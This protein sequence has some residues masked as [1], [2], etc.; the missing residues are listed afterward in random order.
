MRGTITSIELTSTE[1][2][3]MQMIILQNLIEF[4]RICRKHGIPYS[5][6][7]GTMLGAVRHKGFIPWDPDA[8]IVIMQ[9]DYDRFKQVCQTDLDTE[10]FFL[11]DY[12]TDSAYRW[13]YARMLRKGT[14]YI[15]AGHEHI[16]SQ[17]GVFLDIFTMNS[18]PDNKA[19]R[20]LHRVA[21][22]LIRKALWAE[23]GKVTHP[24]ALIRTWLGLLAAL[25]RKTV[26]RLRDGLAS[27]C[28]RNEHTELVRHMCS[29]HPRRLPYG[30][31]RKLFDNL[32]EYE[33]EGHKLLGFKE[34]DFYLQSIYGD[35]MTPPPE[36]ERS[37][38]IPCSSYSLL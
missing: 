9:K 31:P 2:R 32:I 3:R 8:D 23:A 17:N 14:R 4:D 33:F 12:K 15:R 19:L 36:A 1:L 25:P 10:R 34:Y 29:P 13:G 38:H 35:Y 5:I 28:D 21:C 24:N 7:G 16:P 26:F 30:F 22:Y 11:Q 20:I 37:S 18:V 27:W 6:D